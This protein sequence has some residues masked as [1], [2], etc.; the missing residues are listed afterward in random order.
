MSEPAGKRTAIPLRSTALSIG[1][2]EYCGPNSVL[3]IEIGG[4]TP[5]TQHDQIIFLTHSWSGS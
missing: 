2:H 3:N 4:T 5:G 1:T